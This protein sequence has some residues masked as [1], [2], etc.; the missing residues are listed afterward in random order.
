MKI[1][2]QWAKSQVSAGRWVY[3]NGTYFEGDFE[4]NKP[5]G[6]GVWHFKNGNVLVGMYEHKPKG[7]EEEE[8]A[9]EEPEEG[10]EKV[11][12]PKFDL[13]WHSQTDIAQSAAFVNSVEQ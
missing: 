13:V 10:E 11:K 1:Q 4:N 7:E 8:E 9:E 3:P 6:T 12:K 2:G 5:K